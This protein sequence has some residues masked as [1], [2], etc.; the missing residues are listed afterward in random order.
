[1]AEGCHFKRGAIWQS[2]AKDLSVQLEC[3]Y[4]ETNQ[5]GDV[6]DQSGAFA[7]LSIN[8]VVVSHKV[9]IMSFDFQKEQTP[10][11][12]VLSQIRICR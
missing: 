2:K 7:Q 12:K 9:S 8:K 5:S 1:M 4:R 10:Q 11:V 6:S 3:I